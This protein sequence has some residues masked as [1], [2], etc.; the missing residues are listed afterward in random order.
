[1]SIVSEHVFGIFF[2]Y[3]LATELGKCNALS[4]AR[5]CEIDKFHFNKPMGNAALYGA[6]I[7]NVLIETSKYKRGL[8]ARE[9]HGNNRNDE[10]RKRFISQVEGRC[11][12][13]KQ[14]FFF[15]I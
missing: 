9:I 4:F 8:L 3:F 2:H 15:R 12:A 5:C 7:S 6:I 14:T 11:L 10:C 13:K 1:M